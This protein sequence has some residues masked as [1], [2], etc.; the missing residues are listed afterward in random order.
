MNKLGCIIKLLILGIWGASLTACAG[1][2]WVPPHPDDPAYAPVMPQ[3]P[4]QVP[5]LT[6]SLY[7][8][9]FGLDSMFSDLRAYRVGDLLRVRLSEKTKADKSSNTATN[10]TSSVDVQ[11]PILFGSTPEF[12][13]PKIIPLASNKNNNMR[14]QI[15][16]DNSFTG[17]GKSSQNNNLQGEI[18]VTVSQVLPNGNLIIRGE[19][20]ITLNQGAEFIRLIGTVRPY[21]IDPDNSI[22]SSKI[23]N[24]RIT[25]SGT[26]AL[27]EANQQGWLARLFNGPIFPY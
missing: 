12:N 19:K 7:Q 24:P 20:W 15:D 8:G 2:Q 1:Y 4:S 5:Q 6:G 16:S 22:A 21:D 18:T 9:D 3:A 26:G 27:A 25:Y 11:N 10:K 13:V 14:F 17:D 23:A